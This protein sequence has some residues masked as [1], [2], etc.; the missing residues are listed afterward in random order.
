MC[1]VLGVSHIPQKR[2]L[3]KILGHAVHDITTSP[4]PRNLETEVMRS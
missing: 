2:L 4:M 1:Q 3:K